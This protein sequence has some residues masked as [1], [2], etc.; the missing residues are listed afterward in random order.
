MWIIANR[1]REEEATALLAEAY[2]RAFGPATEAD[3]AWWV[4]MTKARARDALAALAMRTARIAVDGLAGDF[5]ALSDDVEQLKSGGDRTKSVNLLP[6]LDPYLMG[7]KERD[8]YVPP[9]RYEW[10]F[11][12][13]GNATAT[14]L[15][16]GRVIGVWDYSDAKRGVVKVHLFNST[17]KKLLDEVMRKAREAGRFIGGKEVEVQ[18]VAR[19]APLRERTAGAFMSPLRQKTEKRRE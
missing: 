3:L 4:G 1:Y 17:G 19:M 5:V 8:R 13:S 9:E 7:Y 18:V 15:R 14:V 6:L 12:R 10:V 11:D 2:L 16:D